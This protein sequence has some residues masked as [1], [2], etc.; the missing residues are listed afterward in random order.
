MKRIING[1]VSVAVLG[2]VI[3][4]ADIGTVTGHLRDASLG[5]LVLAG[6]SLTALTFL[7]AK[8]WQMVARAV[9]LN[10]SYPCALSEYYIAQMVNLVL[11]GGVLGD[12]GR[13]V[14]VRQAGDML[15]A[16]QSVAA[17]RII[18]QVIMFAALGLGLAVA[19]LVPGGIK[20]PATVWVGIILGLSAVGG[21][22]A[23]S[24]RQGATAAFLRLIL[25]L[26]C[27]IRL[28]GLS[29]IITALLIASLYACARATGT[30]IPPAGW[31]TLIPLIL[32]AML[33]P[34]SVA[35]WGWRE[36]AAAA[37]FP[38]IDATPS[39]GIAMG[40]AYGAMMMIAAVPGVYFVM[41]ASVL[42]IPSSTKEQETL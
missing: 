33:I 26:L 41:R 17:D 14:R 28:S 32:S 2:L 4:W 39:A 7:M 29:V 31:F 3:L 12:V 25:H 1:V 10:I 30:V 37:L 20:W 22:V 38:L 21:V 18:G 9:D 15:R 40:I 19:L 5:W 13:A 34:L 35:G 6:V 23:L 8:R 42:P 27:D 36:G 16:A 24:R 11:P